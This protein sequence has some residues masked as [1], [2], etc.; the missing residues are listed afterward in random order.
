MGY[1]GVAFTDAKGLE[2]ADFPE[3]MRIEDE[4]PFPETEMT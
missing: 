3:M 1:A 2:I 4:P